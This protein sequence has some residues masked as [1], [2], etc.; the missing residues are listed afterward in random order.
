MESHAQPMSLVPQLWLV[1]LLC[2]AGREGRERSEGEE[3]VRERERSE[4]G[5]RGGG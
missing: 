5:W 2:P 3:E 1:P 4:E